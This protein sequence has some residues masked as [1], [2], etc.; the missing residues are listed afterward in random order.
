MSICAHMQV[1]RARSSRTI[2]CTL[3]NGEPLVTSVYLRE[4][5]STSITLGF[6][7]KDAVVI[8]R[9]KRFIECAKWVR[10]QMPGLQTRPLYCRTCGNTIKHPA[11]HNHL[12]SAFQILG[13]R[14]TG[15][16]IGPR[17]GSCLMFRIARVMKD[18]STLSGITSPW[19]K[20]VH[21]RIQSCCSS[22]I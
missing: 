5:R 14:D 21:R 1:K 15:L 9:K 17:T 22:V 3:T 7:A 20:K 4:G 19:P 13:G 18:L 8:E 11:E 2:K 16:E 10:A 12:P 6:A